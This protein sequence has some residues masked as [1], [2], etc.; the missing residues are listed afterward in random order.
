MSQ[1][2][3][4]SGSAIRNNRSG[5][6]IGEC[7]AAKVA[8]ARKFAL[9]IA[10][11]ALAAQLP[12]TAQASQDNGATVRIVGGTQVSAISAVPFIVQLHDDVGVECGGTVI[13]PQWVLTAAH[14]EEVIDSVTILGGSITSGSGTPLAVKAHFTH[15][16][17]SGLDNTQGGPSY[18]FM[19]VQL[20]QPIDF[21]GTG[22]QP[23]ALA[24]PD[25]V[26]R[27]LQNPGQLMTVAGWGDLGEG[28][29]NYPSI[30]NEVQVPVVDDTTANGPNGYNGLLDAS[31]IAAGLPDGGKDSCDGDSGGP[32]FVFDAKNNRNVLVGVVSW[33]QGCAE[34]GKPGIY[35]RVSAGYQ[36]IEQTISQ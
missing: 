9:L 3:S 13:A 30:L 22:I 18:D 17:F 12:M 36:W 32:M 24:D 8:S 27:G 1:S 6:G 16:Q 25:F 15:P 14:C 23:I 4:S 34:A 2:R 19:L 7:L 31:M 10:G 26:N 28:A 20:A 5:R 21:T 11:L 35:A 29:Q 33:G